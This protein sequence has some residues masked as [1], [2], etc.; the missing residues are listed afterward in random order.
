MYIHGFG[1]LLRKNLPLRNFGI[2]LKIV[3][4]VIALLTLLAITASVLSAESQPDNAYTDVV[5][6]IEFIESGHNPCARKSRTSKIWGS[7][8]SHETML[9]EVGM[10]PTDVHCDREQSRESFRRYMKI[11]DGL[12]EWDPEE[13]AR[14]WKVGPGAFVRGDY[15]DEYMKRFFEVFVIGC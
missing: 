2:A 10:V 1:N 3:T 9:A 15:P 13:M 4:F 12:H 14:L 7:M 6:A 11:Y 8:Q 5:D